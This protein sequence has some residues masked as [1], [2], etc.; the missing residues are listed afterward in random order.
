MPGNGAKNYIVI[1]FSL[2]IF[3]N[4]WVNLVCNKL[5]LKILKKKDLKQQ[6]TEA[7]LGLSWISYLPSFRYS[8]N[9]L[10][11]GDGCRAIAV[12]RNN[13][14]RY[15]TSMHLQNVLKIFQ[16]H[17]LSLL[18]QLTFFGQT[19]NNKQTRH[20]LFWLTKL[21]LWLV[22]F[23]FSIS[24]D[25]PEAFPS[26]NRY[27]ASIYRQKGPVKCVYTV[28]RLEIWI[29]AMYILHWKYWK[30]QLYRSNGVAKG[31]GVTNFFPF[32]KAK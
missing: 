21:F 10:Q 25:P 32:L 24:W 13:M 26:V 18:L 23:L 27:T 12:Q 6:Y 30:Q 9:V 1:W 14:N 15:T 3:E 22:T 31:S 28:S 7:G 2:R 16:L 19:R 5:V 20:F 17:I 11:E 4:N 29:T 8:G